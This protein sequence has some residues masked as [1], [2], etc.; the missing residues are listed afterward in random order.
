MKKKLKSIIKQAQSVH[1][2]NKLEEMSAKSNP[3]STKKRQE[4]HDQNQNSDNQPNSLAPKPYLTLFYLLK[5]GDLQNRIKIKNARLLDSDRRSLF[6][7]SSRLKDHYTVSLIQSRV[8]IF[9][10]LLF[11]TAML[12]Y[13]SWQLTIVSC[14]ALFALYIYRKSIYK[15]LYAKYTKYIE[16]V[17]R[18]YEEEG[19]FRMDLIRVEFSLGEY[20][21]KLSDMAVELKVFRLNFTQEKKYELGAFE[22]APKFENRCILLEGKGLDSGRR[23][24]HFEG[25]VDENLKKNLENE[26]NE[27]GADEELGGGSV[28]RDEVKESPAPQPLPGRGS[29]EP[30]RWLNNGGKIKSILVMPGE[31]RQRNL[32]KNIRIDTFGDKKIARIVRKVRFSKKR[33][34][35]VEYTKEPQEYNSEVWGERNHSKAAKAHLGMISAS[36][37]EGLKD[38][39][40]IKSF[41]SKNQRKGKRGRTGI[42]IDPK[43][44]KKL[45]KRLRKHN[46]QSE[47]S[48]GRSLSRFSQNQ[49]SSFLSPGSRHQQ[50]SSMINIKITRVQSKNSL[51]KIPRNKSIFGRKHTGEMTDSSREVP[52]SMHTLTPTRNRRPKSSMNGTLVEKLN[53]GIMGQKRQRGSMQGLTG[54]GI[55]EEDADDLDA[56]ILGEEGKFRGE[57]EAIYKKWDSIRNKGSPSGSKASVDQMV[58]ER[59]AKVSKKS[60][61]QVDGDKEEL[62]RHLNSSNPEDQKNDQ[63]VKEDKE[64]DEEK[65]GE[66]GEQQQKESK[67][68]LD[69]SSKVDF[70]PNSGRNL[71]KKVTLKDARPS[72]SSREINSS[73]LSS[74]SSSS[75]PRSSSGPSGQKIPKNEVDE[76]LD[77][78]EEPS[79]SQGSPRVRRQPKTSQKRKKSKKKKKKKKAKKRPQKRRKNDSEDDSS[80]AFSSFSLERENEMVYESIMFSKRVQNTQMSIDEIQSILLSS[81]QGNRLQI[82]KRK[83]EDPSEDLEFEEQDK[84]A[85]ALPLSRREAKL[86]M[87]AREA[88]DEINSPEGRG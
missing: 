36:K 55:R 48:S 65:G 42:Q 73:S 13:L 70:E 86:R 79:D 16:E 21:D 85:I 41:K 76:S 61:E 64:G 8:C 52:Y 87:M 34:D 84:V 28:A 15:R 25:L 9:T 10:T 66:G 80:I 5:K 43:A 75:G 4:T 71:I 63:K 81:V 33:A 54:R 49:P 44:L 60:S 18:R 62:E 26:K 57:S 3:K 12:S 67:A 17:Q 22:R 11:C 6:I 31:T 2:V 51:Q 29:P 24:L 7:L 46:H 74:L 45:R 47:L 69:M 32:V 1:E 38:V 59:Q 35:Q 83:F 88:R 53:K 78:L 39:D 50:M 19:D 30:K 40:S 68:F 72:K 82:D 56:P 20:F 77:N 27:I 37:F 23:M 14:L 58:M